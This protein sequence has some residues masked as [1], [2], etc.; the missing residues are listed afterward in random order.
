MPNNWSSAV[1]RECWQHWAEEG[2]VKPCSGEGTVDR[3]LWKKKLANDRIVVVGQQHFHLTDEVS[4]E[5]WQ[6]LALL[7]NSPAPVRKSFGAVGSKGLQ[8]WQGL[9]EELWH[10]SS[11][12]R[13][14]PLDEV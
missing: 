7:G 14:L 8:P 12:P 6:L 2:K 10:M 9:P 4:E 13:R 11:V 1:G 5:E 3:E